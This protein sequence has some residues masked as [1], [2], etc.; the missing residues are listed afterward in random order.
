MTLRRADCWAVVLAGGDGTRLRPLTRFLSGDE[1]PKQFCSIFG[2]ETLVEQ[3]IRRVSQ[4]VPARQTVIVLTQTHERFYGPLLSRMPPDRVIIQPENRGTAPAIVYALQRIAREAPGASVAFFPSDH[5]IADENR[6]LSYVESVF[7]F[8]EVNGGWVTLLGVKPENPE[9]EYGWVEPDEP[10]LLTGRYVFH[11]VRRFWEKPSLAS[12]QALMRTG[13]LWN[14]FI[15]VGRLHG[16]RETIIRATPWLYQAFDAIK[17]DLN[18]PREERQVE[19]LYSRLRQTNFSQQVLEVCPSKLAVVPMA[20]VGW[21]DLGEPHRVVLTLMRLK[22]QPQMTGFI[23]TIKELESRFCDD[24]GKR[25]EV[26]VR[27]A[28]RVSR[29]GSQRQSQ[30]RTR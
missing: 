15:M 3:T 21:C 11:R 25:N 5:Y 18:T 24:P 22:D 9:V 13:C 28:V 8:V 12:A 16:F 4:A 6:F 23:P 19:A 20:G 27:R 1:R 17:S 26:D 10:L 14:S 7:Q 30:N 2:G 29:Q